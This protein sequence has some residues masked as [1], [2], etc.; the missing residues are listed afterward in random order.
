MS[1]L[2]MCQWIAN[3]QVGTAIRES[4]WTFPLLLAAHSL[5]LS[6]SVG[7]LFW[8]DLRLL[9]VGVR[10]QPVSMVYRQLMPW[11]MTGFFIMFATG[12][13]LFWSQAE[14]VY[15]DLYFRIKMLLLPLA[16]ANAVFYHFLT[17]R[18]RASWDTAPIPPRAARMAG[19]V[20]IVLW[21]SIIIAGRRIL[22]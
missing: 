12:G 9:G 14:A 8:F 7:T 13:L 18:T 3:T 11:M 2:E 19:L 5:G 17:E 21:T 4:T 1:V 15:D 10:G 20:S 22:I 6:V 16:G